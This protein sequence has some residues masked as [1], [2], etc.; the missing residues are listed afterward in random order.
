ML[1]DKVFIEEQFPVSL[2]SKESYKERKANLGQTLTGLGKWWGRK[3]LILIRASITGM[4][5]PASNDPQK[6]RE[7]F[8]KILTMDD[9]GLW[10]RRSKSV[11]GGILFDWLCKTGNETLALDLFKVKNGRASWKRETSSVKRDEILQQ[12]FFSLN[13]DEKLLLCDRPEQIDGPSDHAWTA[14]NEHLETTASSLPELMQ[15]LGEKRFGHAPRIGDAFAGGG[16]IPFEAARLGCEATGTDLNPAAAVLTWSGVNL[17]GGGEQTKASI[18]VALEAAYDAAD[19]QITDWGIEHNDQGWRA[20]AFL[21]CV[22]ATC[23]ATGY[24]LP[25]SPS[26]VVSEKHKSVAVLKADHDNKRYDI[27]IIDNADATTY[28][29]AKKGTI[30][31]GRMVCPE[32]GESFSIAELRGDRRGPNGTEYG[33]RAWENQDVAPRLGDVFQERLYCVRWAEPYWT[34]NAKGGEVLKYHRHYCSVTSDDLAREK[35]VFELLKER[36]NEWQAAGIIPSL[37][38]ERGGDKTEEPIRNRGWTHWHHLFNPRQLLTNGLLQECMNGDRS[39][40]LAAQFLGISKVADW[41]SRLCA[42]MPHPGNQKGN[43]TFANQALNTLF[44]YS[45][46]PLSKLKD[47]WSSSAN[48]T[49][50]EVTGNCHV[51][52]VDARQLEAENDLWI[53]DPPYADAVNYHELSQ[54]FLAWYEGQLPK[55]FPE[56]YADTRKALAVRGAGE[57]FKRSMVEVYRNLADCMP[58]N[59]LADGSVYPSR[60]ICLGGLGYDSLGC[61]VASDQQLGQLLQKPQRVLRKVIMFREQS[62]LFS[63]N[64]LATWTPST[65]NSSPKS[66]TP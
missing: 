13:Y 46:R 59:G 22:E 3:P 43:Q 38:I 17:I 63:A 56:W 44:N 29:V 65:T 64:A 58:D 39:V 32:T 9:D 25:L 21:Y 20:D 62:F 53:T 5:M 60:S 23:P 34:T 54:Y 24:L 14:I 19:K 37:K 49:S 50:Y 55:A 7:I 15:Q 10:T 30:Q 8:L 47:T 1:E 36:F 12:Y 51:H 4:L 45:C 52:T 33:L 2:V 42:W 27:E 28:E 48:F 66:K 41:N 16:S 61:W 57:D 40:Q 31:S 18:K 35:F 26:W 11:S 6:D